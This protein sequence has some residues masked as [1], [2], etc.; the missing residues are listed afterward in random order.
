[1]QFYIQNPYISKDLPI[2]YLEARF[3]IITNCAKLA[4]KM[5]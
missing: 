1:M 4:H 5:T 3:L 2:L